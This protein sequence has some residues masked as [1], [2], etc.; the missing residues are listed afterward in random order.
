[1]NSTRSVLERFE[2]TAE[3]RESAQRTA[4]DDAN[5]AR[6]AREQV[7]VN[8]R[9]RQIRPRPRRQDVNL[10]SAIHEMRDEAECSMRPD[11]GMGRK[12]VRDDKHPRARFGHAGHDATSL[13]QR[14]FVSS[15]TRHRAG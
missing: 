11:G 7:V 9:T 10:P 12:T 13:A 5:I 3:F 4:P 14:G 15:A 6:H 2:K 8:R 1:L